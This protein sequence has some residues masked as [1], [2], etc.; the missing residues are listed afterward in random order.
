SHQPSVPPLTLPANVHEFLR[1]CFDVPDETAKLAWETFRIMAWSFDPTPEEQNANRLKH[2][3]L[4]L[5]HGLDQ[6]IGV[7]SLSPPTHV[8]LDPDCR[9]RLLSDPSVYRDGELVE[10]K[11]HPITVFTL[12]LGAVPG[13]STS[14][15]CRNCH[16]CYYPNYYVHSNATT[17]TY[18]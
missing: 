12:D 5:M 9:Q 7:H 14:C 15:Y 6:R 11:D 10:P 13:F 3:K 4:F 18:Y 17:R 2:I 1:A 16:T 8:C